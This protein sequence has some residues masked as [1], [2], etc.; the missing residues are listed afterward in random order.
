MRSYSFSFSDYVCSIPSS[1]SPYS[2]DI[3]LNI[4]SK[5]ATKEV[6]EAIIEIIKKRS[7]PDDTTAMLVSRLSGMSFV[8]SGDMI[9]QMM[10]SQVIQYCETVKGVMKRDLFICLK[11]GFDFTLSFKKMLRTLKLLV[12]HNFVVSIQ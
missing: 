6:T 12:S 5:V 7:Q 8:N 2:R 3:L 1:A 10:V 11:I 4:L 9:K